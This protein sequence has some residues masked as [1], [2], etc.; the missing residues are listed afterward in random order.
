MAE[1]TEQRYKEHKLKKMQYLGICQQGKR[2]DYN[3]KLHAGVLLKFLP[4][5]DG[6]TFHLNACFTDSLRQEMT[7]EH[8]AGKIRLERICGP[9]EQVDDTMVYG[10]FLPDGDVQSAPHV[11]HLAAGQSSGRQALQG[12]VQQVNLRIPYRLTEGKRQHI[13][14]PGLEDVK[15]G[16]APLPLKAVSDCGLPVY[17]YVK[18]GPARI[19]E[20]NT[21]EFTPIPPRSH[22]PVKVTVVAWQ[23]GLKGKVQT[24]EPVE[25]SFYIYK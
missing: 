16:S 24:A 9:V 25:R 5:E 1:L 12:A 8:A 19:T 2:V 22:F 6:L 23:Y 18:E 17:Y 4:E 14:F 3:P 11:G 21:L 10:P 20:N 15:A 13:L 7:D